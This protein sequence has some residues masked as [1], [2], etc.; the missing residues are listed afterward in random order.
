MTFEL[1]IDRVDEL[2]DHCDSVVYN[3]ESLMGLLELCEIPKDKDNPSKFDANKGG[4][5]FIEL[6][7]EVQKL[8]KQWA[9]YRET[10]NGPD[11]FVISEIKGEFTLRGHLISVN[12]TGAQKGLLNNRQAREIL[13]KRK[14]EERFVFVKDKD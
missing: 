8:L 14:A 10:E 9:T 4:E 2:F 6:G 13:K 3:F 7:Y 12:Y 11:I 5:L 1:K